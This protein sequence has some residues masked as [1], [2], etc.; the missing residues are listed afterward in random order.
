M[1]NL[2]AVYAS[3]TALKVFVF[4]QLLFNESILQAVSYQWATEN[5]DI[6]Y[7]RPTACV[8]VIFWKSN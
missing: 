3:L 1:T 7:A 4:N 2:S 8:V 6:N 5:E